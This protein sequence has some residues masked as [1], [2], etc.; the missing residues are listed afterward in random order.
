M[1]GLRLWENEHYLHNSV[2]GYGCNHTFIQSQYLYQIPQSKALKMLTEHNIYLLQDHI[3]K[4][5][6]SKYYL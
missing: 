5:R 3:L 4:Q 1:F 6:N 2:H